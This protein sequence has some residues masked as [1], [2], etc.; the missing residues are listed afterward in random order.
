M[1]TNK[2]I[3][4]LISI[5]AFIVIWALPI[6]AFGIDGLTVLQQRTIAIFSMF[7]SNTATAASLAMLMP[8]S[9]PPT[10]LLFPRASSKPKTC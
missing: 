5:L 3:G 1:K 10:P 4:L 7:M 2:L 8:I 6:T 9:T